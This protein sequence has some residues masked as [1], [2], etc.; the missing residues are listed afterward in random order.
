MSH[1]VVI[2][3]KPPSGGNLVAQDAPTVTVQYKPSHTLTEDQQARQYS[4]IVKLSEKI[5]EVASATG[6]LP[7]E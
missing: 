7:D 2:I 4:R 3:T 6:N 5:V 1:D